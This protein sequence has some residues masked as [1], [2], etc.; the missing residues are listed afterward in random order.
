MNG[1][2]VE[3]LQEIG[4]QKIY[5]DTHIPIDQ[6]QAILYGNFDGMS[7][8]HFTGFI[9]ILQR[10]YNVDLN[11]LKNE[12][13]AYYDEKNPVKTITEGGIFIA[14]KKSRNF[15]PFY[16]L[17]ATVI[18]L[19]ALFYTA[20]YANKNIKK[21]TVN[22]VTINNAEKN[23]NT[24]VPDVNI[25]QKDKNKTLQDVNN[26]IQD[27][28]T[29]KEIVQ[30]KEKALP[31]SFKIVARTKVWLG[32]I[33]VATNKKYQKTFTGDFDLDPNKEWLLIFGHGY[34]DVIVDA[35]KKEF[36]L[37]TTLRLLY[38]NGTITQLSVDEFKR[39]N[40]GHSW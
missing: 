16:I 38:K 11:V 1:D 31:K 26:T 22:N 27:T 30:K 6:V 34:I 14:P 13:L 17:I 32:Y 5:E 8:V 37:K 20:D 24:I 23:I 10:E 33:D 39:L 25:S 35:E 19:I 21:H 36:N 3:K 9:S 29:T 12:G 40:R 7:K 2:G 4:A 18:F 28:N 15:T